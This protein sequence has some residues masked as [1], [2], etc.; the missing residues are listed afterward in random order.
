MVLRFAPVK[1][2][3]INGKPWTEFNKD[4]ETITLPRGLTGNAAVTAQY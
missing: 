3:T 4:K 1:S 2:V